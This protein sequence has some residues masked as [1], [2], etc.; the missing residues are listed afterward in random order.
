MIESC[1]NQSFKVFAIIKILKINNSGSSIL[2]WVKVKGKAIPVAGRGAPYSCD[3]SR[4]PH[5]LDNQLTDGGEVV[6]LMYW[7]PFTPR[8]ILFWGTYYLSINFVYITT[9]VQ[10]LKVSHCCHIW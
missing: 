7:L 9:A 1:S 6:T 5:I 4:L 3:I 10:N 2:F 8:M